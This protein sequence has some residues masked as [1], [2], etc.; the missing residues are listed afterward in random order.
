V[1]LYFKGFCL[2]SGFNLSIGCTLKIVL[3]YKVPD[4]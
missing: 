4:S 1:P 2:Y 3:L